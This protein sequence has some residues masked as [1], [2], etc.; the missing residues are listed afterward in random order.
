MYLTSYVVQLLSWGMGV[1]MASVLPTRV[2][3]IFGYKCSLNPGKWNAKEHA[4][5]VV[6][7]WGSVYTILHIYSR[8]NN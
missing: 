4:L 2:F 7:Y 8:Y 3:N 1:G 5:I 6:A